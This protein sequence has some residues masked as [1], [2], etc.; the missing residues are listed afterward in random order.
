MVIPTRWMMFDMSIYY[1][2][3]V[4]LN[5]NFGSMMRKILAH[6][7]LLVQVML[8]CWNIHSFA[9]FLLRQRGLCRS[10]GFLFV[11]LHGNGVFS[12]NHFSMRSDWKYSFSKEMKLP[13]FGKNLRQRLIQYLQAMG[14]VWRDDRLHL[15]LQLPTLQCRIELLLHRWVLSLVVWWV[16]LLPIKGFR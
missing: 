3:E 16:V 13:Y 14:Y 2:N 4:Y 11:H 15:Y 12:R 1:S 8:R 10:V 6:F 9:N 5:E 7:H